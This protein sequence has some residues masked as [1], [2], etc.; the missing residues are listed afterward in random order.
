MPP[1]SRGSVWGNAE[2][3][4]SMF[5]FPA[6]GASDL[7]LPLE[8]RRQLQQFSPRG[9]EMRKVR[10][11]PTAAQSLLAEIPV[12][13]LRWTHD[14][15]N[16]KMVFGSGR[17]Q[18]CSIY[19]MV[20]ELF[21]GRLLPSDI[22][23]LQVVMDGDKLFS[24][25]N[26]RLAALKMFQALCLHTV[27][28]VPCE[29]WHPDNQHIKFKYLAYKTTD[30]ELADGIGIR[31]RGERQEA[32]HMGEPLFRRAQEWC[33]EFEPHG[34][35]LL[36][37]S[38]TGEK[39]DIQQL[40]NQ[41]I[42]YAEGE[43]QISYFET[44]RD[45]NK[46]A[47]TPNPEHSRLPG[48]LCHGEEPEAESH[49]LTPLPPPPGLD[50]A[51]GSDHE[52][53]PTSQLAMQAQHAAPTAPSVR[54]MSTTSTTTSAA[55][56]P[57]PV[58]AAAMQSGGGLSWADRLRVS[59]K[60]GGVDTMVTQL[61]AKNSAQTIKSSAAERAAV[62]QPDVA[63][64]C[65][66]HEPLESTS[67]PARHASAKTAVQTIQPGAA[68]NL[69]PTEAQP[70]RPE[71]L[72]PKLTGSSLKP[73][74][75]LPVMLPLL[76]DEEGP[77]G[78]SQG[79]QVGPTAQPNVSDHLQTSPRACV[80]PSPPAQPDLLPGTQPPAQS[81]PRKQ[82]SSQASDLFADES[83]AANGANS[84]PLDLPVSSS[85]NP[86]DLHF[87]DLLADEDGIDE[88]EKP[89]RESS[90]DD[91][92]EFAN[93]SEEEEDEEEDEEELQ[94]S[95]EYEQL[96]RLTNELDNQTD[97]ACIGDL[98]GRLVCGTFKILSGSDFKNRRSHGQVIVDRG[99][100]AM[101][102]CRVHVVGA[103][104]RNRA[105][106]CD[107]CWVRI[108][109]ARVEVDADAPGTRPTR[110]RRS[111]MQRDFKRPWDGQSAEATLL[112]GTVVLAQQQHCPRQR[113]VVCVRS[114]IVRSL[115]SMTFRAINGK[116]PLIK[117]P[118]CP[119]KAIP[120]LHALHVVEVEFWKKDFPIGRF[121][122]TLNTEQRDT[123]DEVFY[124][125]RRS[126]NYCDWEEHSIHSSVPVEDGYF[127][128]PPSPW[129]QTAHLDLRS[130]GAM[131]VCIEHNDWPVSMAFSMPDPTQVQVH[132]VDVTEYLVKE[133]YGKD[134][135]TQARLRACGVWLTNHCD[136]PAGA[137]LPLLQP[138]FAAKVSFW[139]GHDR[140][141]LTFKLPVDAKGE[142][143]I[144]L[145]PKTCEHFESLVHCNRR[146]TFEE[147]E[148]IIAG[149][150]QL[151]GNSAVASLLQS[152]AKLTAQMERQ[153]LEEGGVQAFEHWDPEVGLRNP[154]SASTLRARRIVGSLSFMVNSYAGQVLARPGLWNRLLSPHSSLQTSNC[155]EGFMPRWLYCRPDAQH[156]RSLHRFLRRHPGNISADIRTKDVVE[157]LESALG[158]RHLSEEQQYALQKA[159][160]RQ[161]RMS[162]PGGRYQLVKDAV[163]P[164]HSKHQ[165]QQGRFFCRQAIFHVSAPLARYIDILGLR[166]LK[167]LK[168]WKFG[169]ANWLRPSHKEL[170]EAVDRTNQR[171]DALRFAGYILRQ[172]HLMRELR[173]A[174]LSIN[175]AIV[176]FVG[177]SLFELII[178][179]S[180]SAH[181]SV[182]V[183][184]SA[185]RSSCCSLEF[186]AESASLKVKHFDIHERTSGRSEWEIRPWGATRVGCTLSRNFAQPIDHHA[187]ANAIVASDVMF[188]TDMG[189]SPVSLSIGHRM[190]PEVFSELPDLKDMHLID[191]E[192]TAYASTWYR[193]WRCR[194]HSAAAETTAY[195]PHMRPMKLDLRETFFTCSIVIPPFVENLRLETG[196][197]AILRC[198]AKSM[199][200][201]EAILFGEVSSCKSKG[202][203]KTKKCTKPGCQRADCKFVHEGEDFEGYCYDL[204][205]Q[206]S[207]ISQ[208]ARCAQFAL[209][210]TARRTIGDAAFRLQL[211]GV[212]IVDRHNLELVKA[213]PSK[214]LA[215]SKS[216]ASPVSSYLTRL[217]API[218]KQE[219]VDMRPLASIQ[220]VKQA[221]EAG[222]FHVRGS[223]LN[224]MQLI[225]LKRA[226][227]RRF[228]VVQGPPGTGK[229]TFLVHL[230]ISL[231]NLELD[232]T[233]PRYRAV[234]S[235]RPIRDKSSLQP[236]PGR[237]LV[238][239]PSNQ[240]ADECLR[241]L[242]QESTIP[243]HF[244]TRVYARTIEY[245]YGSKYRGGLE[246]YDSNISRTEHNI[247]DDLEEHSLHYK[248][249]HSKEVLACQMHIDPRSRK[250]QADYDRVYEAIE[251]K[252][253]QDSRVVITTCSSA[254]S[255]GALRDWESGKS[256][257][258][259]G[260]SHVVSFRSVI[261]DEAAQATEPE[262]VL[263]LLRAQD[264]VIIVGDHKQL[265][266]VVTEHNLC[267]AY[268]VMLEKPMLERL[269]AMHEKSPYST[270]LDMQYRMHSTICSFPSKHFYGSKLKNADNLALLPVIS[271]VWPNPNERAVWVDCQHPHQ[272]G[273]VT[274]VG[275]NRSLDTTVLENNTSLVNKGEA[276]LIAEIYC[277][278]IR[279]G[280]CKPNDIAVITP[281]KAQQQLIQQ[282]LRELPGAIGKSAGVTPVGTVFSMQGSERH[283][284]LLSFVRSTAEGWALINLQMPSAASDV[285]VAVSEHNPALRQTFE[286]HLGIAAKATLLNVA[287][288]RAKSGLV[289]VGNRTV[290]TEGSD[291]FFELAV[292]LERRGN[293]FPEDSFYGMK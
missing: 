128:N 282:K 229:T 87:Q 234:N 29:I 11:S 227:Q 25:C 271:S 228:S 178:P 60:H 220:Q 267:R 15:I 218:E 41:A 101:L 212:P 236:T 38:C 59:T 269:E 88:I 253:L 199:V 159:L 188:D 183:P 39:P 181:V 104:N 219:E 132:I 277:R 91:G 292:H 3:E 278:L 95:A 176:G 135:E 148:R 154:A 99:P 194:T 193:I 240:A 71:A 230:V 119:S 205:V 138:T 74:V 210:D 155:L 116:F 22:P 249:R 54:E 215:K 139:E 45:C 223:T 4:S 255:H 274:V 237:I 165:M 56:A 40:E 82:L 254:L 83:S 170:Q 58:P 162:L 2:D 61:Q 201:R 49:S 94:L 93:E 289:V 248:V 207:E 179:R 252:M 226:L 103:L 42:E 164:P 136:R 166:V 19:S 28:K 111:H 43:T 1:P 97:V 32:W 107:R 169:L 12:F 168:G 129:T 197:L 64:Q 125:M 143:L 9:P 53:P 65:M 127:L 217:Q 123:D 258:G 81:L 46:V 172:V 250:T 149:D 222:Q 62:H 158:Q 35:N 281:Y 147:A 86:D 241:R 152:L 204:K 8:V 113:L 105:W 187:S 31:P 108:L 137:S 161:L 272:M 270:M 134:L 36:Y 16:K 140:L 275:Q 245:K 202:D 190:Y 153:I 5:P 211:I 79:S 251:L 213:L 44:S 30:S 114:K 68:E 121:V 260:G 151:A 263:P 186:D 73:Q 70:P 288:T 141:A 283:F 174:S 18:D 150:S 76:A 167:L 198:A 160:L 89:C 27:V 77:H 98:K 233:L 257:G 37:S 264:R 262:V 208:L 120:S 63:R 200:I 13:W 171:L 246:H 7:P 221:I 177:P 130:T 6:G 156:H 133:L 286:S 182:Q 192:L 72:P 17:Q 232:V 287:L 180:S 106:D 124:A 47:A 109:A 243:S 290:L 216:A 191:K 293:M 100:A 10:P 189:P 50:H 85:N 273:Q 145:P 265:G 52:H 157:A 175:N 242:I 285:R 184:A 80:P 195:S 20:H 224:A 131:T 102:G 96:Q 66:G 146:L 244:I 235:Q 92:G 256:K 231:V 117:V 276:H 142:R 115:K 122:E 280:K 55:I 67:A 238:C 23:P 34:S 33:D 247:Q 57:A 163:W 268:L 209:L 203:Y 225:G 206:L 84:A 75:M 69:S 173:P 144:F 214:L 126:L 266:P 110:E 196:D 26:R 48:Q 279:S 24:L 259:A 118:W 78:F 112:F 284:V 21:T 90:D 239:T 51:D 291:D 185:L 14:G 261:V